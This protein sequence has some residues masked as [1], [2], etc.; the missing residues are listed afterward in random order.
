MLVLARAANPTGRS[1]LEPE[2]FNFSILQQT[3]Q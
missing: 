2:P 1:L 3:A